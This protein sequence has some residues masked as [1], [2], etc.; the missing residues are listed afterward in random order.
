MASRRTSWLALSLTEDMAAAATLRPM[1]D[2][3]GHPLER[4]Q[5]SPVTRMPRLRARLAPRPPRPSPLAQ[6]GRVV[7]RRQRRVGRVALQPLLELFDP[8][9]QRGQ[10][11]VLRLEPS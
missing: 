2:N 3:L 8:L 1:V 9:R 5:R 4:K 7:A 10:L 11:G 6:P